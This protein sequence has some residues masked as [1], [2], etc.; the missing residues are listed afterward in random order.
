MHVPGYPRAIQS[1]T[2]VFSHIQYEH[3]LANMMNLALVGTLCCNLV[4]RGI[5]LG[6]YIAAGAMG[7]L[8]TLYWANLGRGSIASH[9]VGASAAS[10]GI[11]AL[12]L[13][14]TDR[15]SVKIPFVKDMEVGFWPLTLLCI[16][17]AIEVRSSFHRHTTI[18]NA[19]HWGGILTGLTVGGYLRATGFKERKTQ[20]RLRSGESKTIDFGAV[21]KEEVKEV[22]DVVTK[23]VK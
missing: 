3:M 10:W 12:Y 11:M 7:S 17:L 16:L 14:V 21:V 9:S 6:T 22:K 4:G 13:L 23:T 20:E 18:D 2:N 8:F 19:S 5:F 1:V 15:D